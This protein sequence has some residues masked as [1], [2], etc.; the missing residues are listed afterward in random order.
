[1]HVFAFTNFFAGFRGERCWSEGHAAVSATQQDWRWRYT[2]D[3]GRHCRV[4]SLSVTHEH[5]P[6]L[7]LGFLDE[8]FGCLQ[9]LVLLCCRRASA[10]TCQ[11]LL[12]VQQRFGHVVALTVRQ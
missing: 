11:R 6:L 8:T 5:G 9:V 1:M 10:S 12:H 4:L 2:T 3:L 7:V